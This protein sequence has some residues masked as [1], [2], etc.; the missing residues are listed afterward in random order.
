VA[1]VI[2]A[3]RGST[4]RTGLIIVGLAH[5]IAM[6]IIWNGLACGDREAA[7]VAARRLADHLR[8]TG[9]TASL[10]VDDDVPTPY[11]RTAR[12]TWLGIT[13]NVARAATMHTATASALP[14][15]HGC[16]VVGRLVEP[17]PRSS[18][19]A[20][21]SSATRRLDAISGTVKCSM[22]R[23]GWRS[24]PNGPPIPRNRIASRTARA[25]ARIAGTNR[26]IT[27]PETVIVRGMWAARSAAV[28][29][30]GEVV[31]TKCV[32]IPPIAIS[33]SR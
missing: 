28:N 10:D 6:V 33:R 5:R 9:W 1:R 7:A 8:E 14:K 30:V 3:R 17:R 20:E 16:V 15:R 18:A 2:P 29:S 21:R 19:A 31:R 11:P 23:I 24:I 25:S 26:S 4:Y 32:A 22:A 27:A 12:E 13:V